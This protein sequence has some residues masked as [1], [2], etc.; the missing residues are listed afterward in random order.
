M[1]EVQ[2]LNDVIELINIFFRWIQ[3][4]NFVKPNCIFTQNKVFPSISQSK[5]D[6][7]S[8]RDPNTDK[9]LIYQFSKINSECINSIRSYEI[10]KKVL[11]FNVI[12]LLSTPIKSFSFPHPTILQSS[13]LYYSLC[14]PNSVLES[15]QIWFP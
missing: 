10:Q 6:S 7:K 12:L 4:K 13:F 3:L 9:H 5:C 1:S 11:E 14:N 2:L 15:F 8:A